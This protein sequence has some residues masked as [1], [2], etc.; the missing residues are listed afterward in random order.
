[1]KKRRKIL[2]LD[3]DGVLN[4]ES[5][6]TMWSS[7][8]PNKYGFSES[9]INEVKRILDETNSEIIWITSWRNHSED[10]IWEPYHDLK[11]K[12]P[13]PKAKE[14]FKDYK[15]S[16]CDHLFRRFKVDDVNYH[17]SNNNISPK[18][19]KW[20]IL[21]DDS[22]QR[23]YELNGYIQV[24]RKYGVTKKIADKVIW[25]LNN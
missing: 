13:F 3:I 5:D 15:Q 4:N 1:M 11:F 6:E 2:F 24:D 17:L 22:K 8:D 20:V 21:D 25:Y 16:I 19:C 12:S 23:L 9:C 7:L 10:F 18:K 14:I